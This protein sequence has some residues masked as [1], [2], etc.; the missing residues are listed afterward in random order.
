M[1]LIFSCG[2]SR[3]AVKESFHKPN[4]MTKESDPVQRWK[5]Y[6]DLLDETAQTTLAVEKTTYMKKSRFIYDLFRKMNSQ[7]RNEYLPYFSSSNWK[8]LSKSEKSKHRLSNIDACQVHHFRTQS[9]FPNT[10]KMN[11]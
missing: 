8:A 2:F 6:L 9:L 4:S 10:T 1:S 3:V 11:P 5:N 7:H